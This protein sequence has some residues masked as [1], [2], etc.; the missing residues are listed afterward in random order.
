MLRGMKAIGFA[1]LAAAF[2][3]TAYAGDDKDAFASPHEEHGVVRTDVELLASGIYPVRIVAID[4]NNVS[5]I[6]KNALYL[7]PGKHK[8]AVEGWNKD[9]MSTHAAGTIDSTLS[10]TAYT[11]DVE[12]DRIYYLGAK[13]N[14]NMQWRPV[15]WRVED[16]DFM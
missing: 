12:D 7:E 11:I 9:D 15:I 1:V 8:L 2:A 5:T 14:E 16:A 13:L 6:T 10:E 3:S 4:G